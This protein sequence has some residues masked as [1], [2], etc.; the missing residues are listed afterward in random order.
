M[1]QDLERARHDVGRRHQIEILGGAPDACVM[2]KRETS[3]D[4]EGNIGLDQA[5]NDSLIA[6]VGIRSPDGLLR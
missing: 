5:A 6:G 2:V 4:G 1:N 3:A